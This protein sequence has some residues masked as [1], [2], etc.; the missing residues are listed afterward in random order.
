[1]QNRGLRP[2]YSFNNFVIGSSPILNVYSAYISVAIFLENIMC[3]TGASSN[4]CV[5]DTEQQ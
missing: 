2:I 3:N 4:I 5:S 1:M